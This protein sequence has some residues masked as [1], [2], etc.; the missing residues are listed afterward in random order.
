[1]DEKLKNQRMSHTKTNEADFFESVATIIEQ[2]RAYVGRTADVTMCVAYFEIGRMIIE[3]EQGGE[4]R[5]EYGKGLLKQLSTFLTMRFKRGFSESTLKNAR[6]FYQVYSPT[7]QRSSVTK[8]KDIPFPKRQAMLSFFNWK[9][10]PQ[11]RANNACRIY[12]LSSQLVTLSSFNA[13]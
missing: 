4:A 6:K 8:S 11:K 1:M 3:E 12:S 10:I 13:N 5:A 7:L 2:A 9:E